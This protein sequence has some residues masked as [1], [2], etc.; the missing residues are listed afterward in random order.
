MNYTSEVSIRCKPKAY[1][2]LKKTY[3]TNDIMP[4]KTFQ[5]GD[6]HILYWGSIVWDEDNDIRVAAMATALKQLDDLFDPSD[7]KT[8]D[9]GYKMFRMDLRQQHFKCGGRCWYN[10]KETTTMNIETLKEKYLNKEFAI[11]MNEK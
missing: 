3:E 8:T 1:E 4:D 6:C 7:A 9:Y 11:V 10:R 2:M 5:D